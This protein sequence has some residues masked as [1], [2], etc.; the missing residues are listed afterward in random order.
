MSDQNM[1]N[2]I[3]RQNEIFMKTFNNGDYEGMASLY[4][5][6]GQMLPPNGKVIIGKS[7]IGDFW[8]GAMD[9]GIK[10]IEM[11]TDEV[12]HQGD[13]VIEVS[14]ATL[15]NEEKHVIDEIKYIVIWK[16]QNGNWKLH[17]DMFNSNRTIQQ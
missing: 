4:T 17:R 12:D 1:K 5:E 6:D 13:T 15:L 11:H 9:M 10:F 14:Q 2:I 8:K 3:S 16:K 7:G